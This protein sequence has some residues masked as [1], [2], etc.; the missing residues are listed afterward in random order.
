MTHG[1]CSADVQTV[2]NVI[3]HLPASAETHS[4]AAVDEWNVKAK[5]R[6]SSKPVG[7]LFDVSR[8]VIT[9]YK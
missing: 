5:N 4:V 1:S 6:L 2:W 7:D 3:W 9:L 8:R